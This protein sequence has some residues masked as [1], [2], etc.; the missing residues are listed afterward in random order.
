MARLQHFAHGIP[1]ILGVFPSDQ[2]IVGVFPALSSTVIPH[3]QEIRLRR[4]D[5]LTIKLQMQDDKDPPDGVVID[6]A[7]L[8]WAAKQGFGIG[9]RQGIQLDNEAALIVKRSYDSS[10]IE[11][12]SGSNGQALIKLRRS[13][14]HLL[15]LSPAIWDLEMAKPI[16]SIALPPT[17]Q[18]QLL[19]SSDIVLALNFQWTDLGVAAGDIFEA[20][21]KR[22]LILEVE[23]TAL[24]VDY[25]GWTTAV[26]P[27]QAANCEDQF[28]LARADIKTVA[29]GPFVVEGDVVR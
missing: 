3:A 24:R 11:V 29:S 8:R 7:V 25:S 10:E 16:E 9:E 12:T 13:D 4:S 2:E 15:P 22:V 21:G 20:Q 14:T 28:D 5:S 19:A 6:G 27:A 1:G 23:P 26:V 17:G 18:V